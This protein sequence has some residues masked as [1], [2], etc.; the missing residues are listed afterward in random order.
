[1]TSAFLFKPKQMRHRSL[2]VVYGHSF[3]PGVQL[4]V[5]MIMW[6]TDHSVRSVGRDFTRKGGEQASNN[7]YV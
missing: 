2:D 3:G 6:P 5:V 4:A 7:W 1:M